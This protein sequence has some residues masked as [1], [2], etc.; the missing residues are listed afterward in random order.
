MVCGHGVKQD[1]PMLGRI[2]EFMCDTQPI[3]IECLFVISPLL[4]IIIY[5]SV[6]T[7]MLMKLFPHK[8]LLFCTLLSCM[9][10]THLYTHSLL[11]IVLVLFL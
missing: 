7:F 5:V 8:T 10:I 11:V 1:I 3:A 2:N 4:T 6:I 9:T